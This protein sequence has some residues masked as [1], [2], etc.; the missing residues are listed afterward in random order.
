ME[1]AVVGAGR[2][3][4]RSTLPVTQVHAALEE[5]CRTGAGDRPECIYWVRGEINGERLKLDQ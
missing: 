4:P 1:G 5:F 3:Y 2:T